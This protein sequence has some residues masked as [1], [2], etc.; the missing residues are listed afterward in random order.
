LKP[1]SSF[2]TKY[3][4]DNLLYIVA[5]DLVARVSGISYEDFIET[6]IFK[7]LGM[8]K[9]AA[10]WYRLKDKSNVIDG[11]APYQGKLNTSWP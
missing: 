9:T 7:P 10:S 3:D 1:V 6:R 8:S 5:G 2:R 4:Y 11:H